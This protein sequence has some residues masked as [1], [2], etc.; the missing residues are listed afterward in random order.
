LEQENKDLRLGN[1]N[2]RGEILAL[3][4][5]LKE[6]ELDNTRKI[7]VMMTELSEKNKK[8][9]T[10]NSNFLSSKDLSLELEKQ[11]GVSNAK[12]LEMQNEIELLKG[13]I[14]HLQTLK[15]PS[16]VKHNSKEAEKVADFE[17]TLLNPSLT[18]SLEKVIAERDN[19]NLQ[20]ITLE[21]DL[22]QLNNL[23]SLLDSKV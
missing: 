18:F 15:N 22:S 4:S 17:N 3:L 13:E 8:L 7:S 10:A 9:L 20:V 19:L 16:I 1:Q 21:R 23:E 11:L 5:R 12:H 2:Q 14:N 6:M